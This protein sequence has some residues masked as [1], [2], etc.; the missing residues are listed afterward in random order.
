MA[1]RSTRRH[2]I[3]ISVGLGRL[4]TLNR[5]VGVVF[6]LGTTVAQPHFASQARLSR[7][8]LAYGNLAAAG[9]HAAEIDRL[10]F[11]MEPH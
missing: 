3:P 7:S 8:S 4:S 5:P 10:I 2:Q 6:T 1:V 11:T 9:R